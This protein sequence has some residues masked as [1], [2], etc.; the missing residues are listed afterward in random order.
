MKVLM[1]STDDKIFEEGSAVRRR[2]LEYGSLFEE[3]HIVILASGIKKQGSRIKNVSIHPTN[4]SRR[5]FSVFDAVKIGKKIIS[6]DGRAP[7][8]GWLVTSQDPFETGLAAW[9]IARFADAPLQLQIHT[10]FFSPHFTRTSLN[11]IRMRISRFLLPRASCV[12]VV[13]NRIKDSLQTIDFRLQARAVVLP[14]FVD[15]LKIRDTKPA[16]DLHRKYPQ[17][18]F[19][20]L[21][22]GRLT[23]E[24]NHALALRAFRD[25]VIDH[26]RAGL[27]I[28]GEGPERAGLGSWIRKHELSGSIVMEEWRDELVSYYKTADAFLLTSHYEGFGMSLV[29]AAA[30]DCPIVTTDVGVVGEIFKNRES[31]LVCAVGDAGCLASRIKEMRENGALRALLKL[32]AQKAIQHLA[33]TKEEYLKRHAASFGQCLLTNSRT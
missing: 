3:L 22:A 30:A 17:F 26:P 8:T 23:K 5:F 10:D 4:S 14:I 16:L 15:I 29:E 11:K 21:S 7:Q 31:A 13:S 6:A 2:M 1:L 12:R 27:V 20:V 25:V 32:N 28:V 19:I 24:K 33:I 18:D 9:R